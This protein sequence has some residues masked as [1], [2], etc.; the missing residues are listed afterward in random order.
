MSKI[1]E[2]YLPDKQ[3]WPQYLTPD[4]F[5]DTP[6]TLNLADFLL[7]RHV[8][9]GRGDN[10]AIKFMD[11]E[12]SYAQLQKM[13][14]QF[15]N[16]LKDAGVEPQ[17]RVGIRLVNAPMSLVTIFAIEKIG[18]IPVPT[19]PLWSREEIAFVVNNAEMKYFVVNAPLMAQ[20]EAAKPHFQCG[21]RVVV[22]G[23]VAEEVNAAGNLVFEEMLATGAP[24]LEAVMLDPYDIGVILYTSGTT[25]M[26]KGCVH[27]I[28]PTVIE[29]RM[30]NKYVYQLKP[31]DILG[32]AAPVSFAA[33]F[34]TFTLIPFEG[35]A[36]I[37]LLPKFSPSDMMEL[38]PKHNITV[39]TGLPTAYRALLKFPAFK[40]YDVGAVRLYTA[41]GDALG[42][43]TL[44][45]WMEL[46]GKPIWE[47]LGGTEMLH[48]VT[49][50]TLNEQPAPNSIGKA[51]PGVEV[52]VIDL[53]GENCKRGE[54]GSMIIRGPSGT[55]YWRPYE[56]DGKLLRS[57][58]SG[59]V[60]GWNK[61]G[62][63]V[64]MGEDGNIFFVAREDDMIKSSG[65]RISPAE[66]EEAMAKH[67]AIADV[68]VVGVPEPEKGQIVK[69]VVELKPGLTA[70]DNLTE[71][72]V[73]FLKDYVALYKLPRIVQYMDKLPRTPTGKLV[74]RLLR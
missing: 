1:P 69:A 25:G 6:D 28:R 41:G 14:N 42:A 35:G 22:I 53:F 74:R 38:I 13:V 51:L 55:L 31:G 65:Y 40:N 36:G 7:D 19:S 2:N 63:A 43:E 45:S 8:K 18:A 73:T 24:E 67:P 29:T 61:M 26:P 23:G 54:V 48:L 62:D 34:G 27:F 57:Q 66:I 4:E 9:A 37:S 71:E 52:R 16:A 20:V 60:D 11:R 10:V 64:Y 58:K 50:N 72:I 21:T 3:T 49:S 17:D 70:S 68:G 56:N 5:A 44:R 32:G 47:G 12:I 33:G 30:V 39:L 59:V 15:G 46:T